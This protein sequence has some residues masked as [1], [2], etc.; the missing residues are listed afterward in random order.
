MVLNKSL[1]RDID[2][3]KKFFLSLVMDPILTPARRKAIKTI[4]KRRG[5]SF[6][7]AQK[8]QARAIVRS[9]FNLKEYDENEE[10]GSFAKKEKPFKENLR[11][12]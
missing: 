12:L 10:E 5:V 2:E 1:K 3:K 9:K 11:R 8:I 6:E 4:M 7:S